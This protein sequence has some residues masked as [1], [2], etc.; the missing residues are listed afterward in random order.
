MSNIIRQ[1]TDQE[2]PISGQMKRECFNKLLPIQD[3]YKGWNFHKTE[4]RFNFL[5]SEDYHKERYEVKINVDDDVERVDKI[6]ALNEDIDEYNEWVK[7]TKKINSKELAL[8]APLNTIDEKGN[9]EWQDV[10]NI[11]LG[12][13]HLFLINLNLER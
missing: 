10:E 4:T 9:M 5:P 8:K 7:E 6:E 13:A 1:L 2:D 11:N 12:S 3:Y